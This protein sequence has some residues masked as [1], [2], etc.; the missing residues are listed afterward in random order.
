MH[1]NARLEIAILSRPGKLNGY[2]DCRNG[3]DFEIGKQTGIHWPMKTIIPEGEYEKMLTLWRGANAKIWL[4]HI[5]HSKLAI[6]LEKHDEPRAL[7]LVAVG[8]RHI[9]GQFSWA[10]AN[11][12]FAVDPS[13]AWSGKE[14][15]Y[16][17]VD[18]ENGFE[19][20]CGGIAL[21]EGSS[22]ELDESFYNFLGE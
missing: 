4:F 6:R 10:K 21:L 5:S 19:L 13:D 11:L 3:A 14:G 15:A 18:A 7:Y 1:P 22:A 9:S 12:S 2:A 17:V 16:R 20:R 8:C